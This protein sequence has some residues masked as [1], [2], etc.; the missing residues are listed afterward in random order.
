MPG[1]VEEMSE[2]EISRTDLLPSAESTSGISTAAVDA[3]VGSGMQHQH[4]NKNDDHYASQRTAGLGPNKSAIGRP[5][6]NAEYAIGDEQRDG[7]HAVLVSQGGNRI[8][9]EMPMGE[10]LDRQG[11]R[12]GDWLLAVDSHAVKDTAHTEHNQTTSPNALQSK[13]SSTNEHTRFQDESVRTPVALLEPRR[14]ANDQH[15][16]ALKAH[17]LHDLDEVVIVCVRLCLGGIFVCVLCVLSSGSK[18]LHACFVWHINLRTDAQTH[19]HMYSSKFSTI[20][21]L[22]WRRKRCIDAY[23]RR[24]IHQMHTCIHHVTYIIRALYFSEEHFVCV[25]LIWSLCVNL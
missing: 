25:E 15:I 4:P 7:L 14:R 22:L 10:Q 3:S 6:Q 8:V 16:G 11:I 2:E 9:E 5:G 12:I 13:C 20:A 21:F 1:S 23:E 24:C 17:S 19:T 18:S